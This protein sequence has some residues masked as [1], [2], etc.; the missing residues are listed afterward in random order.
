VRLSALRG[1]PTYTPRKIP[2]VHFCWTLSRPLGRSATRRIRSTEK[3]NDLIVDRTHDLLAC[4]MM[5]QPTTVQRA[6][7]PQT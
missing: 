4:S 5:L 3:Y 7:E 2:D 1:D 6:P